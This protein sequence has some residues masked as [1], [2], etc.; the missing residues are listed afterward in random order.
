MVKSLG[1]ILFSA[2]IL[3]L[4]FFSVV[5]AQPQSNPNGPWLQDNQ[6][7]SLSSLMTNQQLYD[8]LV[9]LEARSHGKMKLEVAGYTNAPYDNLQKPVGEPLY[10]VKFGDAS[11]DKKRVLV[12]SQIHGNE[13]LGT[14]AMVELIQK[15]ITG[16]PEIDSILSKVMIWF[17]P[18]VNPEGAMYQSNG[19]LYPVRQNQMGWNPISVGLTEGIRAPWYFNSKVG[20]YDVNR[21][22]SPNMDLI[23]EDLAKT[24]EGKAKLENYLTSKSTNNSLNA[25]ILVTP[26]AR[27][28][29]NVYKALKPDVCIDLHHRGFNTVSD[30]DNRSVS[31]QLAASLVKDY[32]D[33]ISGIQYRVKPEVFDLGK[34]INVVAYQSLQRGF[35]SFGA[36]QRYPDVNLPGGGLCA[37]ELNGSAIMLV[38]V[39]GQTQSLGQK[40]NGMLKEAMKTPVYEALKA[41]SDGSFNNVD[42]VLY[43]QIPQSDNSISAPHDSETDDIF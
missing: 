38:E 7:V 2:L 5:Y 10:V 3:S 12:M 19:E 16:S 9:D 11:L 32:L 18:R 15:F 30:T 25:G 4:L 40:Q 39:K 6:N 34:K 17:M 33:P 21:D 28:I 1:K 35:S 13:P 24:I 20:G 31:I 26:E 23:P 36:I 14:E 42:P 27:A 29:T 43:D 8:K 41:L 37:F 22:F